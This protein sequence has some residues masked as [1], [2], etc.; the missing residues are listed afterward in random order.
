[1]FLTRSLRIT[2]F[3][4]LLLA[5]AWFGRDGTR[6]SSVAN[7]IGFAGVEQY[8]SGTITQSEFTA[9]QGTNGGNLLL[10][11]APGAGQ[12][13]AIDSQILNVLGSGNTAYAGS[14]AVVF[15]YYGTSASL[16]A[17]E[18]GCT[19]GTFETASNQICKTS[20]NAAINGLSSTVLN[21][22]IYANINSTTPYT[23][24]GTCAPINWAVTYHVITGLQ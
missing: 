4:V 15:L 10:L 9:M 17:A 18:T 21:Q 16:I 3:T 12:M 23:C 1:M 14:T 5:L 7:A 6:A 19:T 20:V 2:L 13:I 24:S 8:A 11:A 22:G